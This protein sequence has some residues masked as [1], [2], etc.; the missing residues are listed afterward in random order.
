MA[1]NWD[2]VLNEIMPAFYHSDDT[3]KYHLALNRLVVKLHDNHSYLSCGY[4][5]NYFGKLPPAF[6]YQFAGDTVVVSGAYNDTLVAKDKIEC[7]DILWKVDGKEIGEIFRERSEYIT[8]SNILTQ[9]RNAH[10]LLFGKDTTFNLTIIRNGIERNIIAHRYPFKLVYRQ[11]QKEGTIVNSVIDDSIAY[12]DLHLLQ[13]KQ[14]KHIMQGAMDKKAIVFDLRGYP[15][16]TH[17]FI[18]KYLLPQKSDFCH[19]VTSDLRYPGYLKKPF[20]RYCGRRNRNYYKGRVVVLIDENTQS[21][22]EYATMVL[23]LAPRSV[24]IGRPTAGTDG[25]VSTI[26]IPGNHET[27]MTGQGLYYPNGKCP[28]FVGIIPDLNVPLT[29][30]GIKNHDDETLNRAIRYIKDGK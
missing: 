15:N 6:K 30:Q 4:T 28:Q 26:S 25:S 27:W 10:I 17:L 9:R 7:G 8:G 22:G 12:I 1:Q 20:A 11:L 21:Q 29:V 19:V 14:V 16:M 24:C 18:A 13:I 3:V 2:S 23:Q 5:Y